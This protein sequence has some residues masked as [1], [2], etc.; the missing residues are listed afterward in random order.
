MNMRINETGA[1][2]SAP[3]VDLFFAFI[4]A[5]PRNVSSGHGNI[6]LFGVAGENIE[7]LRVLK[8]KIRLHLSACRRDQCFEL[9]VG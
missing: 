5:D 8:H 6:S 3:Y 1:D 4:P 9:F 2:H 7:D